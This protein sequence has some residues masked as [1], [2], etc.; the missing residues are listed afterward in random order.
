M[1]YPLFHISKVILWIPAALFY[2]LRPHGRANIPRQGPVVLACNHLSFLDPPLL[3]MS[4]HRMCRLM[5]RSSL[6]RVPGIGRWMV[7][8]GVIFVERGSGRKAIDASIEVLQRGEVLGIFPEGTRSETGELLPFQRGIVLLAKK[9]AATV[10]PAGIRGSFDAWPRDRRFPRLFR[11][12]SVSFGAPMPAEELL[13]EGG[14]E[15][16]RRRIADLSGQPLASL[17]E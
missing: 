14:L 15:E 11:R 10:V 12:C 16:L 4:S 1:R 5:A 2:F 9:T 6:R 3:A 13:R 8:V 7:A 17:N